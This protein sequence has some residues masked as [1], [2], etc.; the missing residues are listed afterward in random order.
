MRTGYV[1]K[2]WLEA[3]VKEINYELINFHHQTKERHRLESARNY[4]VS[5]LIE[6]DETQTNII[7]IDYGSENNL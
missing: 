4:Y 3:R 1:N 7:K 5:K 6:M 2:D